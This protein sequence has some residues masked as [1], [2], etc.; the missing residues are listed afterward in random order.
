M[1]QFR[2]NRS[3][4][5]M[6]MQKLSQQTLRGSQSLSLSLKLRWRQPDSRSKSFVNALKMPQL[7]WHSVHNK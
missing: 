5:T 4:N 6:Q 7:A 2:T 1:E 3:A